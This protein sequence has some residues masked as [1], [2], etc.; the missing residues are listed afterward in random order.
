MQKTV[1]QLEKKQWKKCAYGVFTIICTWI[2]ICMWKYLWKN[3]QQVVNMR[4]WGQGCGIQADV[5][6][7]K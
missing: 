2:N 5:S 3:T 6:G 1:Q 4:Y 7:G